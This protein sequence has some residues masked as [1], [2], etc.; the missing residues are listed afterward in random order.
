MFCVFFF[1]M[2]ETIK[3][4][5][6]IYT[7]FFFFSGDVGESLLQARVALPVPLFTRFPIQNEGSVNEFMTSRERNVEQTFCK[8][9]RVAFSA[10]RYPNLT[11]GERQMKRNVCVSVCVLSLE[12]RNVCNGGGDWLFEMS[13]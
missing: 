4:C 1:R 7:A 9:V 10:T 13:D 12:I 8:Y 3:V 6:W 5:C 11:V 2:D